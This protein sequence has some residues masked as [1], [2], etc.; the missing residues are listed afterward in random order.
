MKIFLDSAE[1]EEIKK[2]MEWGILDGVTTNPSLLK[3]AVDNRQNIN[4]ENY[5]KELCKICGNKPVSL[6]VISTDYDNIVKEGQYLYDN[7]NEHGNVYVKVPVNPSLNKENNFE[8]IRAI[9]T[10][11]EK[12]IPVNTT[13]IFTPEQ[14][15]MAAKAGSKLVSPFAGRIDDLLRTGQDFDK[16]DYYPEKG[17]GKQDN[18]IVSG[19]DLIKKIIE[20]FNN[21]KINTQVLGASLRNTRQVREAA[22]V[23]CHIVTLP[24]SVLEKIP[25]HE[26]TK[27]GTIKFMEDAPDEYKN[28]FSG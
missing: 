27:E 14:A 11:S 20:I 13:L 3:N 7:F 2:V 18:G 5:I 25:E 19:I 6:E 15:V 9:K 24:F 10:L 26:K 22:L 23:G 21:Y 1:I 16:F 4:I 12:R 8:A 17:T 28:L